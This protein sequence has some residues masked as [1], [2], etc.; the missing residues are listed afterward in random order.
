[1]DPRASA[2][3][4]LGAASIVT[5]FFAGVPAFLLG[6]F[7][8]R[9][10][11][12]LQ[13]LYPHVPR[14]GSKTAMAGMVLGALGTMFSIAWM[15]G[16]SGYLYASHRASYSAPHAPVSLARAQPNSFGTIRVVDLDDSDTRTFNEQL[17]AEWKTAHAA[18]KPLILQTVT[19]NC[20]SCVEIEL[21][22]HD[23]AMQRA[24]SG[25][26]VVRVDVEAYEDDLRSLGLWQDTVPWF[27]RLDSSLRPLD[28]ISADEWDENTASNIAPVLGAFSG[29][30]LFKR[31]SP[32]PLSTSL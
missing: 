14:R 15:A 2:S 17:K 27:Y 8:R 22:M 31:R 3:L 32:S 28:A 21:A 12:R 29:G 11:D 9:D 30:K 24:L 1:M 26:T 13:L 23:E 25:A 18:G 7:A 10:I 16:L 4:I 5:G 20:T 6:A 19:V